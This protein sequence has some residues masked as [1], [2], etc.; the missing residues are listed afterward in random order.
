MASKLS[1]GIIPAGQLCP[2]IDK[3]NMP[4]R[5]HDNLAGKKTDFI[6]SFGPII[7]ERT[8]F[9]CGMA[10]AFDIAEES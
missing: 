4:C 5:R 6:W 9:S 1:N 3:C 10:R 2:F 8:A 7:D